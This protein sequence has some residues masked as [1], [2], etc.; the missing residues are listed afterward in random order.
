M[1]K[2]SQ[3]RA[4]H[5]I[6]ETEADMRVGVVALCGA[7]PA[8]RRIFATVGDPPLRRDV[9]GFEGLARIIVAQ[10]VSAQSAEA[11]WR[12]TR[13]LI[14]PFEPEAILRLE[15]EQL[16]SAGLSA[17][18]IRTFKAL[19]NAVAAGAL[20]IDELA[21]R[22]DEDIAELLTRVKGIGPWTSAIYTMFCLGRADAWAS[23]DL[24]LQLAARSALRLREKP[25]ARKL[26]VIAERW[27][28]W[29]GVAA[30]LLW[31]WYAHPLSKARSR[32]GSRAE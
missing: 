28:P 8:M 26:E 4:A 11:I 16:K 9:A 25:D 29:R 14:Q 32:S 6:I 3:R 12:R 19:S 7:C 20:S 21:H 18:K 2:P 24:A 10:Q 23:G 31:A 5:R 13:A 15:F 17:P 30:R 22:P 1:P 27:R